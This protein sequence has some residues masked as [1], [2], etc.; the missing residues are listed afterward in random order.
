MTV[1]FTPL[2]STPEPYMIL[3]LCEAARPWKPISCHTDLVLMLLP[4]A[5][6]NAVVSDVTWRT[7]FLQLYVLQLRVRMVYRFTTE[8][9][10][11]QEAS[12]SQ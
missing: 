1:C 4:E 6:W 7:Q 10:F 12:I 5:V 2:Q 11:P 8:L 9:L 3:R